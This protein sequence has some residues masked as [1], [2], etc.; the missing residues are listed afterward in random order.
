MRLARWTSRSYPYVPD[1]Q[2]VRTRRY[3]HGSGQPSK[4]TL[5]VP[6]TLP[7]GQTTTLSLTSSDSAKKLFLAPNHV[8]IATCGAADIGGAPVAGFVESFIVEKL[9][10]K[11]CSAEQVADL[12][13]SYLV[14][15]GVRPGTLF[16]VAGYAKAGTGLEQNVFLVDPVSG[17]QSRLNPANQQ[18]AYWG[19]EFDVLQRLLSEVL[20]VTGEGQP[21]VPIPHFGI[22]FEYFTLQDAI[23]FAVYGIRSTIETL[24]FQVREKTVGNPVDV[25]VLTPDG[26]RWIMQKQLVADS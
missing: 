10:G 3:R 2:R 21:P 25:L 15:L 20:L 18:G 14:G 13:S 9:K 5:T 1:H 24:R 8:G 23:D 6:K 4:L 26:S 11:N 22:P 7:D 12:L 17:V 19:G 16:H